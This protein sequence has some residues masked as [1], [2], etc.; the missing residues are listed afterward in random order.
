[1]LTDKWGKLAA[2]GRQFVLY[3]ESTSVRQGNNNQL[4]ILVW[5]LL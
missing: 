4:R 2:W 1:M 5:T 3:I